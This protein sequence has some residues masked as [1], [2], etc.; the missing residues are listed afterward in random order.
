[1]TTSCDFSVA[2]R[3]VASDGVTVLADLND[4]VNGLSVI[5]IQEPDE[6]VRDIRTDSPFVDGTF[7]VASAD[8][9]GFL[10]V[11]VDVDGTTW[12]QC[13]TRWQ[14]V[15]AAYR[16]EVSFYVETAIEGVTT[17]WLTERPDVSPAGLE[18]TSLVLKRQTYSMRFRV[19]PNPTVT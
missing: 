1:M 14:A 6:S 2:A 12:G 7:R 4:T 16:A 15:R 9:D 8:D 13:A 17:T 3:I 11:V 18:A 10:V 5:T 19:Q